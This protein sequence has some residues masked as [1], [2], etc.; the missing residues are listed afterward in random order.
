M[1]I[2]GRDELLEVASIRA[3]Q[4]LV[5]CWQTPLGYHLKNWT[6]LNEVNNDVYESLTS[7]EDKQSLL[8]HILVGHILS[9]LKGLNYTAEEQITCS[10]ENIYRPRTINFKGLKLKGFDIDFISNISLPNNIGLGRHV[11][12]G[13]GNLTRQKVKTQIE[14]A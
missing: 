5:A 11:S 8:N 9:A 12:V 1:H 14:E 4:T 6:P 10:I 2:S 7:I 3:E 13:M